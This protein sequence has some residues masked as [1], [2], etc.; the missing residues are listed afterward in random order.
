MAEAVLA[1]DGDHTICY[2]NQFCSLVWTIIL[3]RVQLSE[4]QKMALETW[5]RKNLVLRY[6]FASL[7]IY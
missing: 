4:R 3:C 5:I 1:T 6:V 2:V 7:F